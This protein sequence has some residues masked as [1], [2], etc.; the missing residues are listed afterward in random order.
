[1]RACFIALTRLQAFL[2]PPPV[3]FFFDQN[4]AR[5]NV[6]AA[7]GAAS[8]RLYV[9]FVGATTQADYDSLRGE[10][11]KKLRDF[12]QKRIES[13]TQRGLKC[14]MTKLEGSPDL[15]G[16]ATSST[17]ESFNNMTMNP[18]WLVVPSR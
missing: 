16:D 13:M 10:F 3:F 12:V 15:A 6:K 4:H 2:P 11:S 1:M 17:A 7:A 18:G 8:A 14:A 5:D 9:A